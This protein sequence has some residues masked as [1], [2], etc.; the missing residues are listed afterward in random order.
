MA[1]IQEELAHRIIDE[2]IR[3]SGHGGGKFNYGFASNPQNWESGI[4]NRVM[5]WI[6]TNVEFHNTLVFAPT[7]NI[8]M[9]SDVF[10][11]TH[12]NYGNNPVKWTPSEEIVITQSYSWRVTAGITASVSVSETAAVQI[13][14]ASAEESATFTLTGTLET[15]HV[16]TEQVDK[17]YGWNV[18]IIVNPGETWE[19]TMSIERKKINTT[20]TMTVDVDLPAGVKTLI[21]QDN[22]QGFNNVFDFSFLNQ[23]QRKWTAQGTLNAAAALNATVSEKRWQNLPAQGVTRHLKA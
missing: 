7:G 4:W 17:K 1:T 13:G 22:F 8:P 16:E 14:V 9:P 6:N 11:I 20:F 18:E 15:E 23:Q 5:S 19:C 12:T 2:A 10:K 3:R 21:H